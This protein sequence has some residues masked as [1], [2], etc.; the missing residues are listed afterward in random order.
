MPVAEVGQ[1]YGCGTILA[2]RS[3][4]VCAVVRSAQ[5][6]G[7]TSALFAWS[8]QV[9]SPGDHGTVAVGA[10][11]ICAVCSG[12]TQVVLRSYSGRTQ[13]VLATRLLDGR[14]M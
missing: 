6:S 1:E 4:Q 13:V 9:T 3:C 2:Q 8:V 5:L 10:M 11:A 14:S 12:R 7:L